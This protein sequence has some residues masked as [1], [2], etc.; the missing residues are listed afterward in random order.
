[1]TRAAA[2]V[3]VARLSRELSTADVVVSPPRPLASTMEVTRSKYCGS[4]TTMTPSMTT[5]IST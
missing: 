3:S 2:S 1:M 4:A 5:L